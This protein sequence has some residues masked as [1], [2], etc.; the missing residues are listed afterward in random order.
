MGRVALLS[1]VYDGLVGFKRVGGA[2][3]NTLVPDLAS[4]LPEPTD[5]GTTYTFRLRDGIR[6]SDG[7]GSKA[8][9]VRY[10]FE[11]LFRAKPARPDYYDGIVGAPACIKQPKQMRPLDGDRRR[12]QCRD[13]HDQ[14]ARARP[15]VPLQARAAVR[16]RRPDRTPATGEKPLPARART[17]SRSSETRTHCGSS[18]IATSRCG[19]GQPSP[20]ASRTRSCRH[21]GHPRRRADGRGARTGGLIPERPAGPAAGGAHPIRGS[22]PRHTPRP[23]VLLVLNTKRPPFDDPRARRAVAFAVDR[24]RL[25]ERLRRRR[26]GADLPAAAAELPR[27]PPLLPV[28]RPADGEAAPGRRPISPRARARRG[29]RHEGDASR[30]AGLAGEGDLLAAMTTVL[31]ETLRQLG[32]PR[33][34]ARAE[35]TI[36]RGVYPRRVAVRGQHGGWFAGLPGAL[37]YMTASSPVR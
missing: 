27:L 18:A 5:D 6:F 7:R 20:R 13:R 9:A 29:V 22:A 26:R 30:R 2:E 8:S 28:H 1:L 3:G 33:G 16:V 15:R 10:S 17:G 37:G 32:Y 25:V 21:G 12:R 31:D 24:G 34:E 4:A 11:R 14:A 19:R 36:L 35:A 23:D